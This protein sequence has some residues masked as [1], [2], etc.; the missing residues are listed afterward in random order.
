MNFL[1]MRL[2]QNIEMQ[3]KYIVKSGLSTID[4]KMTRVQ[5]QRYGTKRMPV[6]LKKAGFNC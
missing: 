2:K 5:A 1:K 3:Q 6:E 4:T